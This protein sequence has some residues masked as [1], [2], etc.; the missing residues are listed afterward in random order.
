MLKLNVSVVQA[1]GNTFGTVFRVTTF[2]ESHGEAVGCVID[3]C[4]PRIPLSE[5]DIQVELDRRYLYAFAQCPFF[6]PTLCSSCCIF[7]PKMMHLVLANE[8]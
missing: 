8:F 4:P 5:A 2:G 3:G 6:L 7:T 1:A